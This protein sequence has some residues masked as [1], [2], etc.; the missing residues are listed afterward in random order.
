MGHIINYMTCEENESRAIV[1]DDIREEAA[2][3]GDGYHSDVRWHDEVKPLES[4]EEAKNFIE[5]RDKGW[6][7]DHAVRYKDYSNAVKTKKMAEYE[8]K[9]MQLV[10]DKQAYAKEHSVKNFKA[11]LVGCPKCESKLNKSYL[12]GDSCPLCRAE[13]RSETTMNKLKWYDDKIKEYANRIE[14][15]K[16]KQAKKVK[17]M[18]LV[19]YEYHC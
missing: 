1:I 19:K 3:R 15:E 11:K 10:K 16:K 4:Y 17:I 18:W 7:D 13:L 6:Y 12:W 8:Q 5:N 14:E 9:K 2:R